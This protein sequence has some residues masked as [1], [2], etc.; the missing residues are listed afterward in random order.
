MHLSVSVPIARTAACNV[1]LASWACAAALSSGNRN[2]NIQIVFLIRAPSVLR[3]RPVEGLTVCQFHRPDN[4]WTSLAPGRQR[5]QP[6]RPAEGAA[7][8]G[9]AAV[10][11][12]RGTL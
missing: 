10:R 7:R 1:A 2:R 8:A 3:D 9:W 11:R 12:F 4:W 6:R 5:R